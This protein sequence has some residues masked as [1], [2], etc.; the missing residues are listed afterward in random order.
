[1]K[2]SFVNGLYA[3]GIRTERTR[4][5]PNY[6][7]YFIAWHAWINT[8]EPNP[9]DPLWLQI[10]DGVAGFRSIYWQQAFWNTAVP[11][12]LARPQNSRR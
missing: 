2:L 1:M 3:S 7:D 8:T 11:R 10:R 4:P 5:Y 6:P 9:L 12:W